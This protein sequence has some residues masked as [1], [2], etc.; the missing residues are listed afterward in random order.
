MS[1]KTS[2]SL[3]D[4][5][6]LD[7]FVQR[8]ARHM[9]KRRTSIAAL[10]SLST[11]KEESDGER[12]AQSKERS[13]SK[14]WSLASDF[15]EEIGA[16]AY[17]KLVNI[18]S[19][20]CH[21]TENKEGND[22]FMAN[23]LTLGRVDSLR[24][25]SRRYSMDR[26]QLNKSL[27][28]GVSFEDYQNVRNAVSTYQLSYTTGDGKEVVVPD[29]DEA[30]YESS[31]SICSSR[32]NSVEDLLDESDSSSVGINQSDSSTIG[33]NQ[34]KSC[35]AGVGPEGKLENEGRGLLCELQTRIET[36]SRLTRRRASCTDFDTLLKARSKFAVNEMRNDLLPKSSVVPT[37]IISGNGTAPDSSQVLS[38]QSTIGRSSDSAMTLQPTTCIQ[39][40]GEGDGMNTSLSPKGPKNKLLDKIFNCNKLTTRRRSLNDIL[41]GKDLKEQANNKLE[42]L[43]KK[44]QKEEMLN[45]SKT[46]PK[47]YNN[48]KKLK[49]ESS[50]PQNDPSES[51]Q[52][53]ELHWDKIFTSLICEQRRKSF[54]DFKVRNAELVND[55]SEKDVLGQTRDT[56]M[57][58]KIIQS[59]TNAKLFEENTTAEAHTTK[60]NTQ[61]VAKE[62]ESVLNKREYPHNNLLDNVREA[63]HRTEG[64][65]RNSIA[66]TKPRSSLLEISVNNHENSIGSRVLP[67]RDT[68]VGKNSLTFETKLSRKDVKKPTPIT[69][70]TTFSQKPN[71]LKTVEKSHKTNQVLKP[72]RPISFAGSSKLE[73]ENVSKEMLNATPTDQDSV[74]ASSKSNELSNTVLVPKNTP[75]SKRSPQKV[76]SNADNNPSSQSSV[77]QACLSDTSFGLEDNVKSKNSVLQEI[78]NAKPPVSSNIVLSNGC[79]PLDSRTAAVSSKVPEMLNDSASA[80]TRSLNT[81]Q[82]VYR[83]PRTYSFTSSTATSNV[84]NNHKAQQESTV[85]PAI[86]NQSKPRNHELKATECLDSSVARQTLPTEQRF[87]ALSEKYAT[88][89]ANFTKDAKPRNKEVGLSSDRIVSKS[90]QEEEKSKTKTEK[91]VKDVK[92]SD[93]TGVLELLQN[94]TADRSKGSKTNDF[95]GNDSFIKEERFSNIALEEPKKNEEEDISSTLQLLLRN[96]TP[97]TEVEEPRKKVEEGV[98]SSTLFIQKNMQPKVEE[99]KKKVEE[100]VKSLSL[101]I[102]ESKPHKVEEPRKGTTSM[103][104][105]LQGETK[106][107]T[108]T[109]KSTVKNVEDNDIERLLELLQRKPSSKVESE[110]PNNIEK[111]ENDIPNKLQT[112]QGSLNGK[113]KIE[114]QIE[115]ESCSTTTVAQ[116]LQT[117][118]DSLN[119]DRHDEVLRQFDSESHTVS[120]TAKQ[121]TPTL[122]LRICNTANVGHDR[123]TEQS[124][125]NTNCKVPEEQ[126]KK[127]QDAFQ[128]LGGSTQ[129]RTTVA[130]KLI[131]RKFKHGSSTGMRRTLAGRR[132]RVYGTI[133]LPTVPTTSLEYEAARNI[134][135]KT[136]LN[137]SLKSEV[138]L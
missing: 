117:D 60:L 63:F 73:S 79:T 6:D 61:F 133:G 98:T 102:Q 128:R 16:S 132:S 25:C 77:L 97:K 42:E 92:V 39:T 84:L 52:K 5:G 67:H 75:A 127:T 103:L 64:K 28:M 74:V 138:G 121:S 23:E 48:H 20:E 53:L 14:S 19:D 131:G 91:P 22:S 49:E 104:H 110:E 137:T 88:L 108:I 36:H 106:S 1:L 33:I 65:R 101:L 119:R 68:N 105:L 46:L 109:E 4:T 12:E 86:D 58:N 51:D 100:G 81:V 54:G 29:N 18:Y 3:D 95:G 83:S 80:S 37:V 89:M 112:N 21:R 93:I 76:P 32:R 115:M 126:L 123:N 129:K 13:R 24:N 96:T 90:H 125:H 41:T 40:K 11:V 2:L 113:N 15:R 111:E 50:K 38:L 27:A 26:Y 57:N 17:E 78:S 82:V 70:Q 9:R 135:E 69:G 136:K 55:T 87:A 94:E 47:L 59:N 71:V 122:D 43:R 35:T 10:P 116:F 99:P 120:Q 118:F 44:F 72:E 66:T 56:L 85:K 30:D 62:Q 124:Y 107:E 45:P 34:L 130:A 31:C 114:E 7:N 134:I 8:T